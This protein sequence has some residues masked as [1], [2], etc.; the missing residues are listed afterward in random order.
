[1]DYAERLRLAVL[2]IT[3]ANA[4]TDWENPISVFKQSKR[5]PRLARNVNR[6]EHN[7]GISISHLTFS[8]DEMQLVNDAEV[9][10]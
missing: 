2:V 4:Q 8:I 1:M 7:A 9:R 5:M 3:R 10:V 6:Y